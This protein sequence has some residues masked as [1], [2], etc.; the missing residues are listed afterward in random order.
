MLRI[1]GLYHGHLLFIKILVFG[2]FIHLI[3]S[4]IIGFNADE[5]N[6]LIVSVDDSIIDSINQ[7]NQCLIETI[8]I[9]GLYPLQCPLT[10]NLPDTDDDEDY[11]IDTE[12]IPDS[13]CQ[14]NQTQVL[15]LISLLSHC[16]HLHS[17]LLY[18][19]ILYSNSS[20]LIDHNF[21]GETMTV[22]LQAIIDN[23]K[24]WPEL[25]FLHIQSVIYQDSSSKTIKDSIQQLTDHS[26]FVSGISLLDCSY[27]ISF[28]L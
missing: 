11:E 5:L 23:M 24:N 18:G 17:I 28:L 13:T 8:Q 15:N 7:E 2:V 22:L 25:Q 19:M 21:S 16:N 9:I 14:L 1:I 26:I 10:K 12:Y 20:H 4:Y 3:K 27:S 6:D